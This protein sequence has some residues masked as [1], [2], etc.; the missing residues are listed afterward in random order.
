MQNP[1]MEIGTTHQQNRWGSVKS[2]SRPLFLDSLSGMDSVEK[3]ISQSMDSLQ[4]NMWMGMFA[5]DSYG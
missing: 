4:H 3:R 2:S 1:G 5:L